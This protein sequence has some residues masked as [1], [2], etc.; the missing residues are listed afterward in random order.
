MT[1]LEYQKRCEQWGLTD[2]RAAVAVHGC[3]GG[4]SQLAAAVP[5]FPKTYSEVD[6][7]V[8]STLLD[9]KSPIFESLSGVVEETLGGQPSE[10][11]DR[12]L[13]L[14][15]SGPRN[16][17]QLAKITKL[18]PTGT[19]E[20]MRPF[21]DAGMITAVRDPLDP[22]TD[23]WRISDRRLRF[24]YSLLS[25]HVGYWKRGRMHDLLWR[26][27]HARFNRYIVRGEAADI[28]RQWGTS[29][30]GAARLGIEAT[31]AARL[32]VPDYEARRLRASE[33]S[34]WSGEDPARLLALGTLRWGLMMRN[35][36]LA[37]LRML[38]HLLIQQGVPGA[39]QATLVCIGTHFESGI[40]NTP[41]TEKFHRIG[42]DDLFAPAPLPANNP[43]T[44]ETPAQEVNTAAAA[45]E[46]S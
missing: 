18:G 46:R 10:E 12:M 8:K 43:A 1:A 42:P 44:G 25:G 38:Q 5:Y 23:L 15:V 40:A 24:Y 30:A 19:T 21:V 11:L 39:D 37:R 7:W 33:F 2:P 35:G 45:S 29:P 6:D 14:L 28:A 31:T 20:A 16:L 36:Q 17:S 26:R 3:L 9:G 27:L 41:E 32:L 4:D 34:L 22:D 13:W